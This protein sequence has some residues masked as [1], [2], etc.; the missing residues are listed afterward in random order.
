MEERE[1]SPEESLKII[2]RMLAGT[3][4]RFYYNGFHFLFWGTLIILGCILQYFME[5][6]GYESKTKYIWLFTIYLSP[7]YTI[8]CFWYYSRFYPKRKKAS[9]LDYIH[10]MLW[11]AFGISCFVLVF[12]AIQLKIFMP[13]FL[14]TMMGL[15]MFAS[16]AIFKF[17]WLY[18]GA[19]VFW[20]GAIAG[21]ALK[22]GSIS[23][24]I[25]AATM[26]LGYIIPGY[27]L[28]RKAKK[29]AHV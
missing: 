22:D 16:G 28:W 8:F 4:N 17:R 14:F 12:I 11:G 25:T 21:A 2:E 13:P 15:C 1:I 10:G 9:P 18:I 5:A 23:L 27:L 19:V 7:V 24:L 26:F 29:E 3:R 20:L 6:A